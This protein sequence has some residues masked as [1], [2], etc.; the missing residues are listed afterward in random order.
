[1]FSYIQTFF[2]DSAPVNGALEAGI[3]QIDL[4]FR[5]KPK[6]TNN[7]SGIDRPGVEV[8]IISVSNGIPVISDVSTIRPNE[9]TEH[10]ARFAPRYEIARKEWGEII[11]TPD[12]SA[13]TSFTF[14]SP[15]FVK[16]RQEYGIL[17]KIDGQEDYILWSNKK[18]SALVGTTTPSQG[19]SDKY[20]GNFFSYIGPNN[21]NV[22]NLTPT[23]SSQS[24]M[25]VPTLGPDNAYVQSNWKPS[26]DLDLKFKVYVARY[27]HA[28]FPVSGNTTIQNDPKYRTRFFDEYTP[29]EI[30]DDIVRLFAP[31][32]PQEFIEYNFRD[33]NINGIVAG[34]VVYQDTVHWPGGKA[35]P[36]TVSVSTSNNILTAN[37]SFILN[38]GGTFGAS[39]GFYDIFKGVNTN[40]VI[41]IDNGNQ[42]NIR[43]VVSVLANNSIM[44]DFPPFFSNTAAKIKISPIG[45][46]A[47]LTDSYNN[48]V[49]SNILILMKSNANSSVRF[50]NN[51]ITAV[52]ANAGGTGYSNSDHVVFNGF[53]NV[54]NKILGG[55]SAKANLVTNSTGGVTAMYLSNVGAGFV[56]TSWLTGANVLVLN[57][58]SS[59]SVGTGLTFNITV[60]SVVKCEISNNTYFGNTT[61]L[62][63]EASRIKPEI[64]VN[65]PLGT[66]F[67]VEHQSMYYSTADDAVQSGKVAYIL[68]NSEI[69][70]IPVKIF[71][72]HDT[73]REETFASLVPSRSNQFIIPFANG[74]FGNTEVIGA[75]YSNAA[76]Y[77]F[78]VS[79]NNDYVAPYFEPE[80]IN[81][82]YSKYIINNDYT[83]EHTNYGN[84]FAKHVGTKVNLKEDRSAEDALVYLTALRPVG[85]DIKVYARIH[86]NADPEAFDDK[87]WTLLELTDGIGVF[88]SSTD[89]SDYKEY[90]Y[91]FVNSPNTDI[92]LAGTGSLANTT[93]L[94]ITGS[95]TSF[96]TDLE[97]N[98]LVKISQPLFEANSFAIAVV[99]TVT[100]A[101][102]FTIR[103][104][105]ANVGLVGSGLF[106]DKIE[107]FKHQVFNNVL[108][109][110]IARYYN[111]EMAEFDNYDTVQIKL[112]MLSDNDSIVPKIDDIRGVFVTA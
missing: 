87:D 11:A 79:S 63:L 34:D 35:N 17:I 89:S 47:G 2:L 68:A 13:P 24:N 75:N 69:T 103:S 32:M 9:P 59:N 70:S 26:T 86:N 99:D 97:A 51:S 19:V 56:N 20:V 91:N 50:V 80:I 67:T 66:S 64:T 54:S 95:G 81:S 78:D 3:S 45:E 62:N 84:A 21:T 61:V 1:M 40:E 85:T 27:F 39:N 14:S 49:R 31:S 41:V 94:V 74:S 71:K 60:N 112:V 111:S 6:S 42:V 82:H 65:N 46:L 53:E 88:S 44:L 15:M 77:K 58:S 92:R 106:I 16:T 96:N 29:V 73:G 7:K 98:N 90:T 110:N 105:I 30:S 10:G 8:S 52:S 108:N 38:G 104:P 28:G 72:S 48:G 36:L 22:N 107:T 33:S 57:S 83:N 18:G 12:A 93:T 23:S 55:Y 37:A 76:I 43:R 109:D 102:S 100:N 5:A 101:T 25:V 4:Y